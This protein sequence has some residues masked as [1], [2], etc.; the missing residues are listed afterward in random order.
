MSESSRKIQHC[1]KYYRVNMITIR[2]NIISKLQKS[3]RIIPKSNYRSCCVEDLIQSSTNHNNRKRTR[4]TVHVH[5]SI[6]II[7]NNHHKTF[8][9]RYSHTLTS[10][11][12]KRRQQNSLRSFHSCHN[13][14]TNR[15]SIRHIHCYIITSVYTSPTVIT[16]RSVGFCQNIWL[17]IRININININTSEITSLL[18]IAIL[19]YRLLV[20]IRKYTNTT[21]SVKRWILLISWNP[22]QKQFTIHMKWNQTI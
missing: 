6:S 17:W 10:T 20:N 7:W 8:I 22:L 5:M 19:C 12:Q 14:I 13:T 3:C 15:N 11:N 2:S 1:F 16:I 9:S 4:P 21:L 18:I